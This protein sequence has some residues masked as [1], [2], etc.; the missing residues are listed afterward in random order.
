MN[1]YFHSVTLD[2]D[3]CKGCTNCIKHCPTEAI[4]VRDGKAV[5]K[6]E[7]CIDCGECIR[8]CPNHA[9]VAVTDDLELLTR[10][11]HTI[12]L[13]AP[14]FMGQFGPDALPDRILGALLSLGFDE[15]FEVALA[16]EAVTYAFRRVIDSGRARRPPISA[17]CPAVVRLLQVRFPS[18]LEH[19][20]RV[21]SPME[22]AARMAKRQATAGGAFRPAEVGAFFITPCPA[23]VTA[24][25]QPVGTHTSSVD[26]AISLVAA[27]GEVRKLLDSGSSLPL[28]ATGPG[29]GWGRAGGEAMAVGSG[30][31]LSVDGIHS[32]IKVLEEVERGRL[33]EI[34]FIEAQACVGGC[35]GGP[36]V[37]QNPFVARVRLRNLANRYWESQSVF[38]EA[39]L[40][41]EYT[42]GLWNM[43]RPIG[44][45]P[46][47]RLDDDV[48]RAIDKMK[49]VEE[50]L[51][52]LPGL[53]CGSCGAPSCR[54]LA[55]DIA[56]QDAADTD[57]IFILRERVQELAEGVVDLASK[58]P[59]AIRAGQ[60]KDGEPE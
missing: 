56:R 54:A 32:V 11:R 58:L 30:T 40:D 23:K 24:I 59:P 25:K 57:C 12:A 45:R 3:K 38:S 7:R 52:Q 6:E 34:D 42:Q 39:Q 50:T 55:E 14:A 13:P 60:K 46:V 43:V 47:M 18:L 5:I 37:V 16:A 44:P 33:E 9:K 29:L 17:A 1:R 31:L 35:I 41:Q 51:E 19:L 48:Q 15:V 53:D 8:I 4:R 10:F 20:I 22:L 2:A 36:L 49:L 26:G 27:Y 28:R 21:E